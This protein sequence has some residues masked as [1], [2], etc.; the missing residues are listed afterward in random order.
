VKDDE[1]EKKIYYFSTPQG[2]ASPLWDLWQAK[3]NA[4]AWAK[5]AKWADEAAEIPTNAWDRLV[6]ERETAA[7]MKRLRRG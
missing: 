3:K 2:S 1:D 6:A 5:V 4:D 7:L